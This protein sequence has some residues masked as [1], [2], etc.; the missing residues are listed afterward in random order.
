M[1]EFHGWISVQVDDRDDADPSV[2]REREAAAETLIRQ[3]IADHTDEFSLME[4]RRSGNG[5]MTL[6]AHGLRNHR[7]QEV[8]SLFEAVA[9]AL[10][11]SYG[12]LYY[13]D[14]EHKAEANA[15]RVLRFVRGST[16]IHDDSLLSP[17]IPTI[18]DGETSIR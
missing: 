9:N 18:E 10:P 4:L 13:H 11:E 16:S 15:F 2:L 12:L 6:I 3:L 7:R 1:F 5:L 17:V 8:I 14:D